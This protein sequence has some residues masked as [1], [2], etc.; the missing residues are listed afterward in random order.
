MLWL[1]VAIAVLF[2][3]WR[4]RSSRRI[5]SFK[6]RGA[7]IVDVRTPEEFHRGH[8]DG[9][10]NLPLNQLRDAAKRLDKQKPILLCCASGTRSALAAR[11]LAAQGFETC[12]AGPWT[13][14]R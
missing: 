9:A 13:R 10:L 3:L 2:I 12:N 14:I 5:A 4:W 8:V 6:A 1:I 11:Q 7:V